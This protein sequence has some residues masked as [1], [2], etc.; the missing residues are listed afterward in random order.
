[1]RSIFWIV[2]AYAAFVLQAALLPRC[3]GGPFAP[4]LLLVAACGAVAMNPGWR[5]IALG[6]VIGL[7]GDC[8]AAGPLGIRMLTVT[9]LAA[10]VAALRER[11]PWRSEKWLLLAAFPC[12]L[13]V[14]FV[15]AAARAWFASA[16]FDSGATV[17]FAMGGACGS[18]AMLLAFVLCGW[19]RRERKW[20]PHW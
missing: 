13:T 1:M 10:A 17:E 4:D 16:T 5:G 12:L 15:D 8:L 9:L 6:A 2:A 11:R 3:A 7:L 20:S 19:L 18:F 14:L